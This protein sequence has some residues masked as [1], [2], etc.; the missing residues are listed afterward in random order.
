[1]IVLLKIYA[2]GKSFGKICLKAIRDTFLSNMWSAIRGGT[3]GFSFLMGVISNRRVKFKILVLKGEPPNFLPSLDILISRSRKSWAGCL[4]CLI[5][6]FWIESMRTICFKA[7]NLWHVRLKMKRWWQI[8][9]WCSIYWRL[10][11]HFKI[12]SIEGPNET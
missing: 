2:I 4:V 1:M 12:K 3:R 10:S 9:W 5:Q 6:W 11:I 7:T 8:F